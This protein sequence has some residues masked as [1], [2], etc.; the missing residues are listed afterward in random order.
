MSSTICF[1]AGIS[2]GHIIPALSIAQGLSN[3]PS[4]LLF[5]SGNTT[6]DK[7]IVGSSA[8]V[9]K[10]VMFSSGRYSRWYHAPRVLWALI[11]ATCQSI[12]YLR[13]YK[14][15]RVISTG[16]IIAIPVCI[17]AWLLR[18]PIE[19]YEL[20]ATPG[21][22]IKV[23]APLAT[24][25]HVC[26]AQTKIPY[27]KQ[28][29]ILV[30]AYPIRPAY[31]ALNRKNDVRSVVPHFSPERKTIF[32]Q[33][34]SQG[35]HFINTIVKQMV[36][37][38]PEINSSIQ[39]IHQ[40]GTANTQEIADWYAQRA[41]PAHVFSFEDDMADYYCTAD[42]IICRSG[43]GALF[44]TLFFDKPCITIPLET[45]TNT[46]QVDN[47]LAMAHDHPELFT[48]LRQAE[49]TQSPQCLADTIKQLCILPAF[50]PLLS[51]N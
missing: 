25:I 15:E 5:F 11:T 36:Q 37:D 30:T 42:L 47:A 24:T 32:I 45:A 41:I 31:V 35:S 29:H 9:T 22:A 10:H 23:L 7:T 17:A 34:G 1:A 51:L 13:A 40:T 2:G 18:I 43:A 3:Q 19:L 4:Q 16:G 8:L 27:A 21:T 39:I 38:F 48:V 44:E 28:K 49:L 12:Y 50:A 26:F 33:G 6:L 14:P 46:H 20:N